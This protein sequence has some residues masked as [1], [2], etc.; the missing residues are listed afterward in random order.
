MRRNAD[1]SQDVSD[2]AN[3]PAAFQSA[4]RLFCITLG[5]GA[6]LLYLLRVST[7]RVIKRPR[8]RYGT[9]LL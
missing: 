2:G 9:L 5:L 7:V 6:L 8:G 4:D 1:R 3:K